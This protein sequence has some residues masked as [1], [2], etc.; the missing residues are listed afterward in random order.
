[1]ADNWGP[2]PSGVRSASLMRL[3]CSSLVLLAALAGVPALCSACP[4]AAPLLVELRVLSDRGDAFDRL[5]RIRVYAG[6]CVEVLRPPA[7]REPGRFQGQL[8]GSQL[9]AMRALAANPRLRAIDPVAALLA[10]QLQARAGAVGEL[11]RVYIS[12]P[13]RYSL[14]LGEGGE[15]VELQ[16]DSIFQQAQLHPDSV[17]LRALAEAAAAVLALDAQPGLA[18]QSQQ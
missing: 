7:H 16:L 8:E 15:A 1:M 9:Q 14:Q 10:A 3:R 4:D 13:T 18:R 11:Q 17:E 12:H 5:Q 2:V 6:G